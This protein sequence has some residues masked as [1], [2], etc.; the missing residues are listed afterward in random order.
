MTIWLFFRESVIFRKYV[1]L[2]CVRVGIARKREKNLP[3]P[4]NFFLGNMFSFTAAESE[5]R[6]SVRKIYR[7][8]TAFFLSYEYIFHYN[9]NQK[10]L[11][12]QFL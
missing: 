9:I 1:F 8:Q 11:P 2:Y 12:T 10:Y 4:N 7:I 3:Y 5:L 6:E